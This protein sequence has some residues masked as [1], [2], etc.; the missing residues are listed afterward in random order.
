MSPTLLNCS[1]MKISVAQAAALL[2]RQTVACAQ[3]SRDR[4]QNHFTVT[5]IVIVTL[6]TLCSLGDRSEKMA[7]ANFERHYKGVDMF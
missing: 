2:L 7:V 1:P 5:C 3:G 6:F 4:N